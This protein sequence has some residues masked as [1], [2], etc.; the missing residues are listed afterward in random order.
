[1]PIK[2]E[3]LNKFISSYAKF[4]WAEKLN[5]IQRQRDKKNKAQN[6]QG[7]QNKIKIL[8]NICT[9]KVKKNIYTLIFLFTNFF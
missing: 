3:Q 8:Q 9:Q 4:K 5:I 2:N 1:M 7:F 6:H